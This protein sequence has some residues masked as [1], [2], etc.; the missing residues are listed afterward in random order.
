MSITPLEFMLVGAVVM[1][2]SI[3]YYIDKSD[4]KRH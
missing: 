3:A 1:A 2:I 4:K